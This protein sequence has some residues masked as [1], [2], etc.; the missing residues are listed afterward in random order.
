MN[1]Q[2]MK[3][4]AK[5][6]GIDFAPNY[7]KAK[8]IEILKEAGFDIEEDTTPNFEK[9]IKEIQ[10]EHK[11]ASSQVELKVVEAKLIILRNKI[12]ESQ[13]E[14][15]LKTLLT[16]ERS[17]K[18]INVSDSYLLNKLE[19]EAIPDHQV[20]IC[21]RRLP[22]AGIR[23]DVSGRYKYFT[24]FDEHYENKITKATGVNLY[25][26]FIPVVIKGEEQ[27]TSTLAAK[28]ARNFMIHDSEYP[29]EKIVIHRHT[30][31]ESEFLNYFDIPVEQAIH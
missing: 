2:E 3:S 1:L 17:R 29:P 10:L 12:K 11:A 4:L 8:M 23:A 20:C 19:M 7:N 16:W 13:N 25:T 24:Y 30:L 26:F 9:E 15:D 21:K 27:L 31:V 14:K 22:S 5:E 18:I 28:L 6:Q